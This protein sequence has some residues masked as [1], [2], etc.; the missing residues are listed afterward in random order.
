V[1]RYK[2]LTVD[3]QG[4]PTVNYELAGVAVTDAIRPEGDALIRTLSLSGSPSGVPY[5]RIAAGASLEEVGKG[6]YAVNDRS[7][8]VRFDP[9]AKVKLRQN[10]G[11]QELLLPVNMKNGAGSVQYSIVL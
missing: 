10:K 1:L 6:T 11:K 2:G 3:K 4:T 7:Y 9:K 8:Y 5:C